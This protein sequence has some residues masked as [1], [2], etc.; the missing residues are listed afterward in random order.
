MNPLKIF[1]LIIREGIFGQILE[2]ISVRFFERTSEEILGRF[3]RG[4]SEL[5]YSKMSPTYL[6]ELI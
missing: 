5:V 3:F 2:Q 1:F 6:Q 4:V